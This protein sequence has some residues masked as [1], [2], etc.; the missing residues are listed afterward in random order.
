[1]EKI[2]IVFAVNNDY[3]KQLS[4]AIISILLNTTKDLKF[5]FF[6]LN[7]DI[8]KENKEKLSELKKFNNNS[9]FN[10]IDMKIYTEKFDLRKFMSIRQDYTYISIETYYR[11]FIPEILSNYNKVIYLDADLILKDD[12]SV[13]YSTDIEEYYAGVVH[14]VVVEDMLKRQAHKLAQYEDLSIKDYFKNK[15]KISNPECYFNAG[16]LV[17]NLDKIRQ[18]NIVNEL[19]NFV[20]S[21]S[22]LEYQDQDALNAI[23]GKNVKYLENKWNIVKIKSAYY[24]NTDKKIRKKLKSDYKN[25]SIFHFIG[26]D[27]PW[28]VKVDKSYKYSNIKQWWNYYQ[29]S[30]FYE[31][32]D[33]EVLKN[34]I[35][36]QKFYPRYSIIS[37][38]IFNF[39]IF[40]MYIEQHRFYI[41]IFG[42]IK[43]RF[44]L[45]SFK[46]KKSIA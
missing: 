46:Y 30:P 37:L 25:P 36:Q 29:M 42:Y 45:K 16:V 21:E 41:Y 9:E 1:M 10:F 34:I 43:F 11:F 18:D 35:W 6:I 38:E 19:W 24:K 32:Q 31:K 17:L 22:P 12:I 7:R 20:A 23:I 15:L 4:V 44:K 28:C 2:P 27:K 8:S 39:K 26:S 33:I 5:E 40:S 3:I 14:D 13:L